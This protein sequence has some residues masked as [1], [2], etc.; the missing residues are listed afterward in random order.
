VITARYPL[1][2]IFVF[3]ASFR[4]ADVSEDVKAYV[5]RVKELQ[6]EQL[7]KLEQ[8]LA[9]AKQARQ[10]RVA[11]LK[12]IAEIEDKIK[13]LKNGPLATPEIDCLAIQA[14]DVGRLDADRTNVLQVVSDD[15][16]LITP[17]K[18]GTEL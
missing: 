1:V 5:D 14:G 15:T 12:R 9:E 16:M 13:K 17:E 11:K 10:P 8:A 6:E 7:S 18:T 3:C 2:L 4:A